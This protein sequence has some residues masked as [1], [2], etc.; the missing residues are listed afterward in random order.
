MPD[1]PIRRCQHHIPHPM[2]G[3]RT[4]QRP[5]H[6]AGYGEE[7]RP[8]VDPCGRPSGHPRSRRPWPWTPVPVLAHPRVLFGH[9][10]RS[11][12]CYSLT[13]PALTSATGCSAGPA[14]IINDSTA[15]RQ[16]SRDRSL[17]D[18]DYACC[19]ATTLLQI[20]LCPHAPSSS[21]GLPHILSNYVPQSLTL[22]STRRMTTFMTPALNGM[23]G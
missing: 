22:R 6:A 18:V 15:T 7:A 17:C 8:W 4:I 3:V 16:C 10:S 19:C 13:L 20:W 5:S 9:L 2:S 1:F 11:P 21:L 12:P 14:R 23:L